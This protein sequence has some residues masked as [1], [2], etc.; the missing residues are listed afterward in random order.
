M[1]KTSFAEFHL[2]A[3]A[4]L[5]VDAQAAVVGVS[6]A[7]GAALALAIQQKVHRA[8]PQAALLT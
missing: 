6:A 2:D 7:A 8:V 4:F 5:L 3:L 1:S